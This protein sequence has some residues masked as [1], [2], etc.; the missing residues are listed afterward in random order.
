MKMPGGPLHAKVLLA[1]QHLMMLEAL[2]AAVGQ[3]P[4]IDIVGATFRPFQATPL[5][6]SLAPDVV[7]LSVEPARASIG[8]VTALRK[9]S[10][11]LGVVILTPTSDHLL[12]RKAIESGC[13]AVIDYGSSINDLVAAVEAAGRG[14]TTVPEA[15]LEQMVD[16]NNHPTSCPP[17]T[18]RE[19]QIL[20]L[21]AAGKSTALMARGLTLSPH[22]VRNHVKNVFSKL[23]VHTRLEA[24]VR[25][26]DLGL[27]THHWD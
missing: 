17:L 6:R 15:T 18:R 14:Q 22:T 4:G 25:G 21:L 9:D 23:G 12:H 19:I 27:I 16:S 2:S 3:F 26:H 8:L 1:V 11:G 10:A 24:V 20:T 7:I 5:V 13:A